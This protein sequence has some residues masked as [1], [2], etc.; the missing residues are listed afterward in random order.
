MNE[1]GPA[2]HLQF[3]DHGL[4]VTVGSERHVVT[5]AH[6]QV[7]ERGVPV[8]DLRHPLVALAPAIGEREPSMDLDARPDDL[9]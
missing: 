7:D 5:E 1:Y 9:G 6:F 3:T 2:I 4:I 8:M